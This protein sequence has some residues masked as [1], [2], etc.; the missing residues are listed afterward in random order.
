MQA[1]IAIVVVAFNRPLS[2]KRLL[3]SLNAANFDSYTGV[4]L[5]ISIDFSGK[6]DCTNIAESFEWEY[7]TKTVIKRS[8]NLGLKKH[9]F[10]CGDLTE[11]HDAIIML[12][13]D[14]FVSP[15]FYKFAQQAYFFYKD[16]EIIAGVSLYN[17][18]FNEVAL[19]PFEPVHD[20]FDNY[21]MQVPCS[22]GQLWTIQQWN[23]FRD[24]INEL[25]SFD[26]D[27][28]LPANVLLWPTASSWK[29]I[30]Y[31]YLVDK[32]KYFVYPRVSLTTNFGEAGEHVIEKQL[33][34]QSPLLLKQKTFQFSLFK[35]S[36]SIYDPYFELTGECYNKITG[37]DLDVSFDLNN[38]K[39]LSK[40]KS[41]YLISGKKCKRQEKQYA[42][43]LYPYENNILFNRAAS[44]GEYYFSLGK[45][46]D[47]FDTHLFMR[48]SIDIRRLFMNIDFVK[49]DVF[50]EMKLTKEYRVGFK[51]LSPIF[52]VRRIIRFII[53]KFRYK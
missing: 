30:F 2:L 42:V 19:C 37:S 15:F 1:D 22:W 8:E 31:K 48:R 35:N 4:H 27:G 44:D 5:I 38:T 11:K 34:F 49:N 36:F 16:E 33:V 46:A 39:Q 23:K 53:K 43:N 45:T 7:G 47:F 26:E 18:V 10:K 51:I 12:E 32:G 20:G 14:L 29:K 17:N 9:I 25:D 40:V 52:L 28:S 21:F 6:S 24:Y 13:D 41:K 3:E 50:E